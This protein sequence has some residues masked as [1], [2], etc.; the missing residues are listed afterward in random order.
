MPDPY[1]SVIV[2]AHDRRRYLPEA[3]HSLE[4]QT[5]SKD[6]FEVIVV[7][8]FEDPISDEIIRRNGWK[9]VVTDVV[10]VGSKIAIGLEEARGEVITFLE[11]DD[12]YAPERLQKVYEAFLKVKNIAYFHNEQ[13]VIDENNKVIREVSPLPGLKIRVPGYVVIDS[14]ILSKVD[15]RLGICYY[16]LLI[17]KG[18]ILGLGLFFNNSSLAIKK[19][20]LDPKIVANMSTAVDLLLF[21]IA[22]RSQLPI[23]LSGEPLTY[24]RAHGESWSHITYGPLKGS[25]TRVLKAVL[26]LVEAVRWSSYVARFLPSECHCNSYELFSLGLRLH[27]SIL[28]MADLRQAGLDLSPSLTEAL[29][30]LGCQL[31]LASLSG[32]GGL[33]QALELAAR[34]FLPIVAARTGSTAIK[35]LLYRLGERMG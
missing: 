15:S 6:K 31:R 28:P 23:A 8:N 4:A 11:D 21:A 29:R 27:F 26:G 19:V 24:Y 18:K 3:L 22:L 30:Y 16:Q 10:P 9:N 14:R 17:A 25:P 33:V 20:L 2:T 32:N 35:G 12:M 1:V 34:A 13:V 5:L 7:K